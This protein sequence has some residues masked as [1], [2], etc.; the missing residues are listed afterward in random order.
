MFFNTKL[1]NF[2][3]SDYFYHK[4]AQL[5]KKV[6][7]NIFLSLSPKIVHS[8]VANQ[9]KKNCTLKRGS[10]STNLNAGILVFI[11][12]LLKR[13]QNHIVGFKIVCSGKWK[14]TK[15]GRK[16]VYSLRFGKIRNTSISNVVLYD[17]L[18][19]TTKF[20]SFGIKV[21]VSLKKMS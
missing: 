18:T 4:R 16:Q 2:V 6:T 17:F 12:N 11:F 5:F 14:K 3:F 1:A 19:Q 21:W 15:S 10:F 7:N 8:Y 9:L 20:G 13:V